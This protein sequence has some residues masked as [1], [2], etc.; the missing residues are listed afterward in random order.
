MNPPQDPKTGRF[1]VI[2]KQ[3]DVNIDA[4]SAHTVM[5]RELAKR[6]LFHFSRYMWPIIEP[7]RPF[8]NNWHIGAICEHLE[9]LTSLQ[10]RRL[11]INIPPR[12]MKS[13][14][15]SV[16]WFTWGWMQ[17]PSSQWLYTSYDQ[18]LVERDSDRCR[19]II[20]S[21][22]YRESF[23]IKWNFKDTQNAIDHFRN[24]RQGQRICTTPERA[25]TG[26]DADYMIA[27]DPS[28]VKDRR[29]PDRLIKTAEWWGGEMSTRGNDPATL[30]RLIVMQRFAARDLTGV[31]LAKELGY[32]H[33][34]FP[35]EYE[36]TR[37]CVD[38]RDAKMR[39]VKDP[40]VPTLVQKTVPAACDPRKEA[41]EVLWK[42]R[43]EGQILHELKAELGATE[44][45][46]QLQQRPTP[47]QGT[48][49]QQTMFRRFMV[50]TRD[51]ENAV[52]LFDGDSERY[53]PMYKCRMFQAIDTASTKQSRND[54]TAVVTA[55]LTPDSDL[56][57]FDVFCERVEIPYLMAV[58]EAIKVGPVRWS[59]ENNSIKVIGEWPRPLIFQAV[60]QKSSGIG[61]IQM[62]EVIGSPFKPLKADA[63]KEERAGPVAT[64][65]YLGK[66]YHREG[67]PWLVDYEAEMLA[68][69][70][71]AHDDRVDA[72]AFAGYLMGQD[73]ILRAYLNGEL[74]VDLGQERVEDVVKVTTASGHV[75]DVHFDED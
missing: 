42:G 36:P 25:G 61:I 52:I 32:E 59:K 74:V 44:A 18:G 1:R 33:C 12:H 28:S 75:I 26:L 7:N 15:C 38:F 37:Y 48:I 35:A 62:G 11:I 57:I 13:I 14:L 41:G 16:M 63:G 43:F 34:C 17:D 64:M 65:Y 24:T 67:A 51:G 73:L 49:F 46:G 39:K 71:G 21:E 68:F 22:L 29:Y 4:A 20:K 47:E 10:I 2:P 45:A 3:R 58:L 31:Q 53:Y 70:N 56:L 23:D 69:P 6:K 40:I 55:M 19:D 72:T 54:P 27:D 60:E 9:A 50:G 8:V 66:V 5:K 30:R